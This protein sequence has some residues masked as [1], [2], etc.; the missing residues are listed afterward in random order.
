MAKVPDIARAGRLATQMLD[1]LLNAESDTPGM[2]SLRHKI[3]SGRN[4]QSLQLR[5]PIARSIWPHSP[6]LAAPDASNGPSNMWRY[7]PVLPPA[8]SST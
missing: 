8:D 5:G 2:Q 4:R 1:F 7:A 3:G 6:S